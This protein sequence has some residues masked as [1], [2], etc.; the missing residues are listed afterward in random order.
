MKRHIKSIGHLLMA[1]VTC[2]A[3]LPIPL[4]VA[5]L[6]VIAAMPDIMREIV[7]NCWSVI[8]TA[9]GAEVS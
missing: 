7:L 1:A 5:L 6:L 8:L 9:S 2:F 4:Q 3:E